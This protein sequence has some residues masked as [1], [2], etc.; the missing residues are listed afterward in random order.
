MGTTKRRWDQVDIA[1][2]DTVAALR[3]PGNGPV[4][5]FQIGLDTADKRLLWQRRGFFEGVFQIIGQALFIKPLMNL[6]VLFVGETN[7]K[8]G[9]S[10][11]LAR[12]R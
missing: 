3:Q 1:F 5:G 4:G 8:P 9:Q 6:T 2:A 12:N 7:S 11:A 10:T